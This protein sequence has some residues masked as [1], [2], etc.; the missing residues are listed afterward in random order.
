MRRKLE[1]PRGQIRRIVEGFHAGKSDEYVK[2]QVRERATRAG[3]RESDITRA[4]RFAVAC[5]RENQRLDS[6]VMTGKL[7]PQ[8]RKGLHK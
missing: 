1:I 3:W 6:A 8:R 4:E 2:A 5:H 7:T